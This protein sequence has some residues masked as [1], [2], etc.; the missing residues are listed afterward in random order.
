MIH[1]LVYRRSFRI[2]KFLDSKYFSF[3]LESLKQLFIEHLLL[4]F[5]FRYTRMLILNNQ[6]L[7]IS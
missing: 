4:E 5:H 2:L 3:P 6:Y 7:N 1:P